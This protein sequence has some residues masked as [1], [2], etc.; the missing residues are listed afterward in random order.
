MDANEAPDLV[1][2]SGTVTFVPDTPELRFT[3]P[4]TTVF[5]Q[6]LTYG[7]GSDGVLR[8]QGRDYVTLVAD[9]ANPAEWTW[10]AHIELDGIKWPDFHF[11]LAPG[12][13]IDL[14]EVAPVLA[15]DGTWYTVGPAGP[16]GVTPQGAWSSATAYAVG[17]AVSYNGSSYI[18]RVPNT[19]VTPAAGATWM[20]LA[21]QGP[22]GSI[23]NM[24]DATTTAKGA[25]QLAGDI[26]GTAAVPT[27]TG[28][29]HHGHTAAQ[30]TGLA[31]VATTGAYLDLGG[32]PTLAAVATS[33]SYNDLTNKPTVPAAY[34]DENAQDAAAVLFA[35]GTHSGI[36]FAYDD[37]GNKVNAAVAFPA[38]PVV[39][40]K[41]TS[42]SRASTTASADTELAFASVAVG[43]YALGGVLY[44]KAVSTG[45]LSATI[46]GTATFNSNSR[47]WLDG[48]NG[49][50]RTSLATAPGAT[51]VVDGAP[52]GNSNGNGV[53]VRGT[54]Q[55]TSAGS[56]NLTWSSTNSTGVYVDALSFLR[57]T[58]IA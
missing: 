32:R 49:S 39:A 42:T 4:P 55:V 38:A 2:P 1:P 18:A 54:L 46:G 5:L 28:G 52:T 31:T 14:T 56:I 36:T 50:T 57:L 3:N 15:E 26:G 16:P 34:T 27:V 17:D 35:N 11:H 25:V 29:T 12:D 7:I 40:L 10:T 48:P 43:T 41:A 44:L 51:Q 8:D 37:A 19:N 6:P 58:K 45:S 22:A 53:A 21:A 47:F 9:G 33:G 13:D 20:L 24:P 30:V 23:S